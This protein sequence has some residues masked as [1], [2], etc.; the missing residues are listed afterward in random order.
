MQL[1]A[2]KKGAASDRLLEVSVPD[3]G[4]SP[5]RAVF[6][7]RFGRWQLEGATL[8]DFSVPIWQEGILWKANLINTGGVMREWTSSRV[9]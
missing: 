9:P 5:L 4:F 3:V 8:K 2:G 6:T 1:K 7:Q